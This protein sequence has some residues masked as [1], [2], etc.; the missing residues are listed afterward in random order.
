M[1]VCLNV[2]PIAQATVQPDDG[3]VVELEYFVR[4]I[5]GPEGEAL[6]GLRVDKRQP[7]GDLI[8]REE[9]EALTGSI[10]EATVLAEAFAEGTVM[11]CV[12][13][14]MVEE[15]FCHDTKQVL[16]GKEFA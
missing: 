10:D 2:I 16:L 4:C 15:W 8:E 3:K 6:Y 9:T 7:G 5:T 12:L 1:K 14:E 11:P 13:L